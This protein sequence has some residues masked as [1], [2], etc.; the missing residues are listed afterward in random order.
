[1]MERPVYVQVYSKLLHAGFDQPYQESVLDFEDNGLLFLKSKGEN[2]N[3]LPL[4]KA[5][6]CAST[7]GISTCSRKIMYRLILRE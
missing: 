6:I 5:T 1:M 3:I 4:K 2:R 7:G